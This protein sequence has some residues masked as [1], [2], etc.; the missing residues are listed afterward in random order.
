M[1]SF[2]QRFEQQPEMSPHPGMLD[3]H[4]LGEVLSWVLLLGPQYTYKQMLNVVIR[5][6][7]DIHDPGRT[8]Q[9]INAAER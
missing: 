9:E 3:L 8:L 5:F 4:S 1:E 2:S 6:P 7:G